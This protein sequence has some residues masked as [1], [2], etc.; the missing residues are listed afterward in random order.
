MK[1]KIIC[2]RWPEK[3]LWRHFIFRFP[4]LS[5]TTLAALTPE[6]VEVTIEDENVQQINFQ[7]QPDLVAVSIITPLANRGYAIAEQFRRISIPVVMGGFHA[8]W[9]AE[10]AGQH[11]DAVVLGEAEMVWLQVIE[12][13]KKGSLKK[14]YQA[15]GRSDLQKLPIPRRNLLPKRAYFFTNTMQISRGCPFQCD[16]CSVTAFF[17]HTC[18]LRPLEEV[19][20]EVELLLQKTNFIFFV[21]DNI[22]GNPAYARD[23]FSILKEYRVKWLS[24]AS[25]NIG[26]D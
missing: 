26:E 9:M 23:L 13:F 8:T 1:I 19:R 11:A 17:G 5:L 10:E 21:D 16:F 24:H 4:Y 3:S 20:K 22:I 7:D 25:I 14:F 15:E 6:D 12:D 18:R 2:P